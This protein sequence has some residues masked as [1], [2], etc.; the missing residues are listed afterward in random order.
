MHTLPYI[1]YIL[2]ELTKSHQKF[3]NAWPSEQPLNL[4]WLIDS[5]HIPQRIEIN[6]QQSSISQAI[7]K[8]TE[9]S[10]KQ[11][12]VSI[13]LRGVLTSLLAGLM[14][15]SGCLVV[16]SGKKHISEPVIQTMFSYTWKLQK[17][18]HKET[19]WLP[20]ASFPNPSTL[21]S[22]GNTWVFLNSGKNS[23][24]FST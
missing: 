3:Y 6:K 14:V 16:S 1:N 8:G 10:V 5:S 9:S 21:Y 23:L 11:Q 13:H 20:C 22:S 19:H 17:D 12:N 24:H 4:D 18:F 2:I 15:F 7:A